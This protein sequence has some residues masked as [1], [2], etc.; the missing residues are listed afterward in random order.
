M[1]WEQ[2]VEIQQVVNGYFRALDEKDLD[3]A[4][5]RRILTDDVRVIRPNGAAMIGPEMIGQSHRESMSRFESTQHIISSHD[6]AIDGDTATVRANLVAI[7]IWPGARTVLT[8]PESYFAAGGVVTARLVRTGE[9]W[10][11][12]E[13]SNRVL[14]RSGGG[15]DRVM[16][17]GAPK[18]SS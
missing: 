18:P 10:R 4:H 12:S 2:V 3:A 16:A 11:I 9:V 13:M 5:L 8:A 1:N 7:H 17:T 15:F 14:W 6:V